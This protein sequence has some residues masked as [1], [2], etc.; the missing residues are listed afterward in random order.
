MVACVCAYKHMM[1]YLFLAP[2]FEEVEA[3]T[4]ADYLRRCELELKLVG[5]GGKNI[6]GSHGITVTC[7][8]TAEE[9]AAAAAEQLPEMIILPGGMPGTRNLEQSETVTKIITDCYQAG[10]KI[11]AI[12]AAPSVL[13]HMG[14]LN[15][16]RAVCFPGFEQ[17]L[18]GAEIVSEPVVADGNTITSKGAGTANHFA[19]ALVASLLG[20][21]RADSLKAALQWE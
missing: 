19:F 5:V 13:G 17:E 16:K 20:Q 18:S 4:P 1:I 8:M 15:G 21:E 2:G 12:C 3:L 6:T 10:K 11:A 7:D 9:A 14:L